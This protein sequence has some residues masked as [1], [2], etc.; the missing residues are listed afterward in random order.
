[1]SLINPSLEVVYCSNLA[2][3][4]DLIRFIRFVS[5]FTGSSRNAFFIS[6]K[7]KSPCRCGIFF[8]NFELWNWTRASPDP[9]AATL[10]NQHALD[11]T[12]TSY[13]R[14]LPP[15]NPE[16]EKHPTKNAILIIYLI[17]RSDLNCTS[18]L[19]ICGK[20]INTW[21]SYHATT[22]LFEKK[23]KLYFS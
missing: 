8:W 4:Y 16:F 19:I 2:S 10:M 15:C 1:M 20:Q 3:N 22:N 13:V 12:P 23:L 21:E 17:K 11:H 5:R 6:S 9:A 18:K 14:V 7:F